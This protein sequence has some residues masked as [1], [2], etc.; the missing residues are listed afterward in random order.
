[1]LKEQAAAEG[2][3]PMCL[4]KKE[5]DMVSLLGAQG[6]WRRRYSFCQ[7]HP[8]RDTGVEEDE[9]YLSLAPTLR[10]SV[11][12]LLLFPNPNQKLLARGFLGNVLYTG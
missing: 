3:K 4:E 1:M 7:S 10:A 11:S 2:K 9:N 5:V 6:L 12:A 8:S